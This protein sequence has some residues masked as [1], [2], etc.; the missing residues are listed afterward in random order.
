M[1]TL[2]STKQ[3]ERGK[4]L[5]T[6]DALGKVRYDAIDAKGERMLDVTGAVCRIDEHEQACP[7]E[8]LDETTRGCVVPETDVRGAVSHRTGDRIFG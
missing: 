4:T 3:E 5:S 1:P 6:G 2:C 8:I 7:V